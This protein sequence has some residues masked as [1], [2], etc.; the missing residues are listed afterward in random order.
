MGVA[1]YYIILAAV[2]VLGRLMPQNGKKKKN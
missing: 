2:I 1:I